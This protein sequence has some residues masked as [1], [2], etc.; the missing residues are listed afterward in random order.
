MIAIGRR[1]AEWA[2]VLGA[3]V[4]A[5]AADLLSPGPGGSGVVVYVIAVLPILLAYVAFRTWLA[6]AVV[7]LAPL[8]F[9]IG[10]WTR[11]WPVYRPEIALDRAVPLQPAWM[12]VYG[13]L[14][15]FAFLL[16]V[17][18]VRQPRLFRQTLKAFL[19]V[20]V[21]AYVGFMLFP[22]AAPR[23]DVVP[24]AGFFPWT[25]RVVYDIDPLHGCFPSLHVAYSFLSAL[26]VYRVHRGVGVAALIWA[27]LIGVSTLFTKQHFVV[28]VI[29]G[30]LMAY[31][32]YLLFLRRYPREE[33]DGI[34]RRLAPRRAIAVAGI[35]AVFVA[36]AW[37]AFRVGPLM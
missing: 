25:L 30:A 34:D 6:S 16:P 13:S 21:T 27:S 19:A 20:M 35:F 18:I 24:G 32:A 23:P 3:L 31:A 29:A 7:A 10:I 22:T 26:T 5:V 12:L 28:D 2:F 17:V 33:V 14:Y 15:V 9:A 11:A 37:A 36:V 1:R 8:Y 4:L